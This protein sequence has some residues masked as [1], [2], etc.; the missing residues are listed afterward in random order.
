MTAN[1]IM[2]L[3]ILFTLLLLLLVAGVVVSFHIANRQRLEKNIRLQEAT[4]KYEQ[5]LRAAETAI[6][7][8]VLKNISHELHDNIGHM[9]TSMRLQLESRMLDDEQQAQQLRPL[10]TTL[11]ATSDQLRLLSRTLNPDFLQHS[12]LI[13]AINMEVER[14]Q[15][16]TGLNISF[17]YDMPSLKT[18]TKEQQLLAFR[19]FQE[20]LSNAVKHA[21]AKNIHISITGAEGFRLRIADDGKGFERNPT[22]E[23]GLRNMMSRA[24]L[25]KLE[26]D[27]YT[28]PGAGC[29]LLLW[30]PD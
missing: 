26:L 28:S 6:S 14:L 20:G 7:E 16:V 2:L 5:E 3:I 4:L 10:Q 27:I 19:I 13:A 29:E 30:L 24:T 8:S 12:D 17:D 18:L 22:R 9:L 15:M 21:Q 23:N 11:I 1:E 25:A